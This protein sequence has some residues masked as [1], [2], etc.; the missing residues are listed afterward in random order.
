VETIRKRNITVR[1]LLSHTSGLE[2]KPTT[3]E[4]YA[5]PDFVQFALA[6][7]VASDPGSKFFGDFELMVRALAK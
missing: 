5:S 6:A 7:D 2:D 4:I 3:Q 1:H